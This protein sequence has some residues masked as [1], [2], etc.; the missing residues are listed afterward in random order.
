[1]LKGIVWGAWVVGLLIPFSMSRTVIGLIKNKKVFCKAQNSLAG[2]NKWRQWKIRTKC[3][4]R[5]M[6]TKHKLYSYYPAKYSLSAIEC[7]REKKM[8]SI[9]NF[10]SY[11]L[12]IQKVTPWPF[13][14]AV[15]HYTVHG[16]LTFL[17]WPMLPCVTLCLLITLPSKSKNSE[18]PGT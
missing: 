5:C 2:L 14:S 13:K 11:V 9:Y 10:K 12:N 8:R 15:G 17:W 1:M 18:N 7:I 16:N 3:G 4:L 6:R